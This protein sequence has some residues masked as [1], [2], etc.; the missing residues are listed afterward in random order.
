M[1]RHDFGGSGFDVQEQKIRNRTNSPSSLVITQNV[2]SFSQSSATISDRIP[3]P[4]GVTIVDHGGTN[5]YESSRD[6]SQEKAGESNKYGVV[7]KGAAAAIS[8]IATGT[9]SKIIPTQNETG[10]VENV[11]PRACCLRSLVDVES[12]LTPKYFEDQRKSYSDAKTRW[13]GR[14]YEEWVAISERLNP[15]RENQTNLDCTTQYSLLVL[16]QVYGYYLRSVLTDLSHGHLNMFPFY[17]EQPGLPRILLLGDSISLGIRV[18]TQH[19]Y[20]GQANIQGAPMNCV[21]FATYETGLHHWLG[22]CPWDLVQFNVGM[23]FHP[24]IPGN[25][26]TWHK[27]Y[28]HGITKIVNEIRAHSPSARIVFALTTPSPFD[29]KATTPKKSTC[30]HYHKFHRARFVPA[31]NKVAISVAK[32]LG[33]IINDR[34]SVILPVLK[35]YQFEC[36]VHFGNEGYKLLAKNDWKAFSAALSI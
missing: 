28:R 13:T 32:T 8:S 36:D 33:I 2:S 20:H 31:M 16:D 27:E 26:T 35:K 5:N 29:S 17:E 4:N 10:I 14:E 12:K 19:L 24:K 18:Q 15:N 1:G 25:R 6:G 3:F 9:T 7:N 30:P 22:C 23:H 34:Y 21:G 11:V